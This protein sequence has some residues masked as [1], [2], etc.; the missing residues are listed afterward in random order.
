MFFR[1]INHRFGLGVAACAVALAILPLRSYSETTTGLPVG[2]SV[3]D[4]DS[5]IDRLEKVGAG[6]IREGKTIRVRTLRQQLAKRTKTTLQLPVLENPA[7]FNTE[8]IY[9]RRSSGVVIVGMLGRRAKNARY[10]VAGSSGFALTSDGVFVT[11]Y[12]VIDDPQAEGL[13]VMTRDGVVTPV[14]EVLAAD[15]VA[16]IAILR[17]PGA[18]FQPLPLANT[19]SQPGAP[20]W[21]IAHPDHNF[22]SLSQGMVSRH[23]MANTEVGRTPQMAITADFGV[24]ASGGPVL[25]SRGEVTGMV[26]STTSVYYSDVKARIQDLQM[27]F[28]HCVPV[29][30]IRALLEKGQSQA[31]LVR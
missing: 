11:N 30:S 7:P 24:G 27:V 15:K 12:H 25:N 26:C 13:V 20:I 28:K 10:E 5:I 9:S 18:Q 31:A 1:T 19:E 6:L 23:F 17:A 4:D 2:Q 29:S 14:T 21:V 16:D 3:V 22:F 8:E